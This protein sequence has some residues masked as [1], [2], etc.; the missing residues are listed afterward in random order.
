MLRLE[1]FRQNQLLHHELKATP[2]IHEIMMEAKQ[3]IQ[4]LIAETTL[5]VENLEKCIKDF[6]QEPSSRASLRVSS[7]RK[8]IE[9]VQKQR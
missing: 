5:Q 6:S 7:M 8:K 2:K 1:E 3:S 9:R 4:R